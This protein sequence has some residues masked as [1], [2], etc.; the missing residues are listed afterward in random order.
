MPLGGAGE[1]PELGG[2]ADLEIGGGVPFEER[3]GRGVEEDLRGVV[4]EPSFEGLRY[5][6]DIMANTICLIYNRR[7]ICLTT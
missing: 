2:G 6:P 4:E 1:A 3:V 5:W 7:T